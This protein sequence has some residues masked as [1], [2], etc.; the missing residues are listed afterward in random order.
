MNNIYDWMTI[1]LK[2]RFIKLYLDLRIQN[3]KRS[4][5]RIKTI[6]NRVNNKPG[7]FNL[8]LV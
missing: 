7:K 3:S 8:Q 2:E 4:N 6:N 5:K 1:V